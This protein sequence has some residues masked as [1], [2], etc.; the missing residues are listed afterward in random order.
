MSYTSQ[1]LGAPCILECGSFSIHTHRLHSTSSNPSS[2]SIKNFTWFPFKT[3]NKNAKPKQLQSLSNGFLTVMIPNS[4]KSNWLLGFVINQ[5]LARKQREHG[6]A[7]F[8]PQNPASTCSMEEGPRREMHGPRTH[9]WS[10]HLHRGMHANIQI[11]AMLYIR[12][13]VINIL[14]LA[15]MNNSKN[16]VI[17]RH[18][19][20]ILVKINTH[21]IMHICRHYKYNDTLYKELQKKFA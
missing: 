15:I 16:Y 20:N 17:H 4:R 5:T 13:V 12:N 3:M 1:D 6:F 7:F 18:S 10:H 14:I 2:K 8:S 21:N 11:N 19:C 9:F